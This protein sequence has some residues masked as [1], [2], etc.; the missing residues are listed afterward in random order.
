MSPATA[1]TWKCIAGSNDGLHLVALASAGTTG[2][3]SSDGGETWADSTV[4]GQY[5]N[6]IT[7]GNDLFVAMAAVDGGSGKGSMTSAD[8]GASWTSYANVDGTYDWNGLVH[9]GGAN[10]AAVRATGTHRV[11]VSSDNAATFSL[12]VGSTANTWDD[13]AYGK[14]TLVAIA[15]GSSNQIMY[16][17]DQG[18]NWTVVSLAGTVNLRAITFDG[19]YFIAVGNNCVRISLDGISWSSGTPAA[20]QNWI[21]LKSRGGACV[22][23]SSNGTHRAM[24]SYDHGL[25]WAL[26]TTNHIVSNVWQ[27]VDYGGGNF[28]A[29]GTDSVGNPTDKCMTAP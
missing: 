7:H 6:C 8:N 14:G 24:V 5:W 20:S 29:V 12:F 4:P 23:V 3:Y 10:F 22:A 19:L 1:A 16:S 17:L 9:M 18:A 2:G 15:A 11:G 25:T 26:Q 27:G 21:A 28:C 13:L